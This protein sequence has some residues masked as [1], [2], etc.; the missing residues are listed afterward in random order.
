LEGVS[1]RGRIRSL[2]VTAAT[3][4]A[5]AGVGVLAGGGAAFAAGGGGPTPPWESSISPAPAGGI[6]FYNAQG[7]VVTGGSITASGLGA[8][9][10]ASTTAS[11][12]AY[13][14]ATLFVFTPVSGENPGLW[15]GEQISSST[16]FP[17][18]AAPGQLGTTANPVET[19][20]GTDVSMASYIA[21]FP[22]TQTAA[23]FVGL[24]DVRLKVTGAGV[25]AQAAY[26]DTVIAVN[27]TNNTWSV[28]FPDFTQ[29]TTTTLSASPPSPQT[30]PASPVT[31]TA[32]V[33]PA[34]AGTV[35]FFSGATQVGATQ[36]V[37]ATN[38]QAQVTTTPPTGTTPYQAIFTPTIGSADIGSA[39]NTL[40]YTVSAPL[41]ATSTSLA[42][43]GAGAAGPVNFTGTVSD[44]TTPATIITAGTVN[45]FDNGSTTPF[46]SGSV[47]AGGAYSITFTYSSAGAHSVV[48]TFVPASGATVAGSS[49]APVTFTETPP[50]CTTCNNVATI[51][52]TV[53]AGTLAIST[54]FTTTNPLNLGTL[55]LNAGG[56]FFSA[57]APLDPNAS[58]V[59]TAGQIPNTTFNGITVVDTQAGNLPWHVTAAASNLSDG[60]GH[61]NGVISGENVGLTGLTPVFVPGNGIVAGD[62][63]VTNQSAASPPVGPTD[64]GSAGL[65]GGTHLIAADSTQADGTVGINGTVTLNAPTSTEAGIFVGTITFTISN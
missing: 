57:S 10:A 35:S 11:N 30:I 36:T 58:D 7:Q 54:P 19:N 62:V 32:T 46:A 4:V 61:A 28:D 45:L 6:T 13:N 31:L 17:N 41:D 40:N 64:P 3:A 27:T 22:N 21:A 12:V 24:Y 48:A 18:A 37:T 44:T 8:F 65:G 15:S 50:A 20:A 39:S 60:S 51:E 53:P 1:M 5:I 59:P 26:W 2:A 52:G 56:T 47:G 33:A 25:P 38:G 9:A 63:T 34:T 55:Q 42:E 23:G 43:T 29:N 49:S 16:T 14:K